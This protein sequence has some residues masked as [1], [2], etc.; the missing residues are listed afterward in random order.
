VLLLIM[1]EKFHNHRDLGAIVGLI[2]LV[3][4]HVNDIAVEILIQTA[5]HDLH[6]IEYI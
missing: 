1:D 5:G 3:R 2:G 4:G 6:T